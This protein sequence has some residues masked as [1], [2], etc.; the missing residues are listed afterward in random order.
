M[1]IKYFLLVQTLYAS[2]TK[3]LSSCDFKIDNTFLC[4]ISNITTPIKRISLESIIYAIEN[5]TSRMIVTATPTSSPYPTTTHTQYPTPTPSATYAI[6]HIP[7]IT[8]SSTPVNV[9]RYDE[10]DVSNGYYNEGIIIMF[11]L[12][13]VILIVNI[14]NCRKRKHKKR[15][16]QKGKRENEIITN[17]IFDKSKV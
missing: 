10:E 11:A 9:A 14:Y 13:F 16:V 1:Y 5:S 7:L 15:V 2:Q 3:A 17:P 6:S 8:P 4:N 12:L